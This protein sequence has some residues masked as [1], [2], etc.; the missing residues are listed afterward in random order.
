MRYVDSVKLESGNMAVSMFAYRYT[1]IIG[2]SILGEE[3]YLGYLYP[4]KLENQHTLVTRTRSY[5]PK[6]A[7]S[8]G[9]RT[10]APIFQYLTY[11][12]LDFQMARAYE[13]SGL[14]FIYTPTG[15]VYKARNKHFVYPLLLRRHQYLGPWSRTDVLFPSVYFA[16]IVFSLRY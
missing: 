4:I 1:L 3:Y 5:V 15:I 6:L 9:F 7:P 12:A 14:I 13:P 11:G 16:V 2:A 10:I 8:P